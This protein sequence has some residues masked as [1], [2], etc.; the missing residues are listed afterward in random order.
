MRLT[1]MLVLHAFATTFHE[2]V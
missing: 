1:H 2:F